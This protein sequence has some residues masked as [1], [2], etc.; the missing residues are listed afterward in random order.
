[1]ELLDHAIYS[2]QQAEVL[3]SPS[4]EQ[5]EVRDIAMVVNEII[6]REVLA[7]LTTRGSER[8]SLSKP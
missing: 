1:M 7:S 2:F 5:N 3:L 4:S 8:L 6:E